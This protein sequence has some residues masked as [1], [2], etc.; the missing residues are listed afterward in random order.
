MVLRRAF[1]VSPSHNWPGNG[2]AAQMPVFFPPLVKTL[3]D[4]SERQLID[5]IQF[6]K[7][8]SEILRNG[9]SKCI[10]TIPA[11]RARL[12]RLGKLLGSAIRGLISI[13]SP[14]TFLRWIICD[15]K[16][17]RPP[18]NKVGRPPTRESIQ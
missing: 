9:S 8:E 4:P 2:H 18:I 15:G 12:L 14:R 1:I 5:R 13:V 3:L 7:A 16:S 11:D 17:P 10:K 6:L